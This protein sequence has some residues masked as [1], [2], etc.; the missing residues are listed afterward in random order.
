VVPYGVARYTG[1]TESVD[2][3]NVNRGFFGAGVRFNTQF[4]T[5]NNG[6]ESDFWDIHRIRHI[7]E[8]EVNLWTGVEN[9]TPDELFIYDESVD[10]VYDISAMQLALRNR[11]QTKRGGPGNWRNVDFFTLNV[12]A[13][14]YNNQPPADQLV[15]VGFRGLFY[16]SAPELSIPR[17]SI[18]AD[19][20]WRL[21]DTTVLLSD[22]QYNLD[23]Q[24]LATASIG[25]I[26][27]RGDRTKYFLSMRW[28]DPLS[29]RIASLAMT[30][31]LTPKYTIGGRFAY[32]FG[33]SSDVYTSMSI[34]R[35][36]D[37]FF[38]LVSV[39]NDANSGESGFNFGIYPEG[40]G[41][42]ASTDAISKVFGGTQ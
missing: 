4:W 34:Q 11:W 12:Q 23:E 36:F 27:E 15:P 38:V 14:F 26:A 16:P 24:T 10:K 31:Q 35:K 22:M 3:G 42:G 29:S 21:S 32:D 5:V 25:M 39:F 2:G 40:L 20:T 13:N 28:I 18:N 9:A 8:P 19:A 1:Y 30:Y 17:N 7:I 37:R 33:D 41:S 6:V